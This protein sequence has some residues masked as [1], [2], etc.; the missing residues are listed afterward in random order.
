MASFSSLF[1]SISSHNFADGVNYALSK[2]GMSHLKLKSQLKQAIVA[3]YEVKDVFVLLPTGIGKS[4]LSSAP[5][6]V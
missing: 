6:S 2:L 4:V 5:F 1:P 3:V